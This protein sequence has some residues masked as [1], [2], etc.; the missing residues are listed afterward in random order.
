MS[1][2]WKK[3]TAAVLATVMTVTI[4]PC[5]KIF[6]IQAA[7]GA[8]EPY[9]ISLGRPVYVSS[10][11]GNL[12]GENGVDGRED[13]RWQASQSDE[14]EWFYVDLGKTTEIDS[15]YIHWEDAYAKSYD[16]QFSD[17][18]EQWETVYTRGNKPGSYVNM[19]ISYSVAYNDDNVLVT[20]ANWTT[21]ENAKYAVYDGEDIAKA[22]DGYSFTGHGDAGGLIQ[23]E[24]GT[25]TLKVVALDKTTGEE[26]GSGI[27][28]V[29]VT[30]GSS[31]NNGVE[32]DTDANLKHTILKEELSATSAR[33]VKI[34]C[35]ERATDYGC[36]FY[37]FQV[38][39]QDGV[40]KRPED[41]G[42]N[43][44]LNKK[45]ECSGLR[46][47]WW[48]T[49][50]E[51]NLDQS[52]VLAENAVDG[53]ENT[54]FTS[55][56]DINQ[57]LS[58]DLGQ[59]YTVGRIV[60]D[61]TGD[62]AKVYDYQVSIDGQK[63]Q[64]VYRNLKGVPNST[65]NVQVYAEN[66][67]YVR[68]Y[69]Y[70]KVE[71]GSGIGIKELS[72]YSYQEGEEKITHTITPLPDTEVVE[73]GKGS[74]LSN[75]M[76][77]EQA[78]VPY[79]KTEDIQTPIDS[80][81]WW[82]SMLIY[83]FGNVMCTLPFKTR[84]STKGLSVLTA[85]DGWLQDHDET[86]VN[87]SV[88]SE[89]QTDFYI[90]PENLDTSSA[91]DK[92]S[93][94]G[95]FSVTAQLCDDDHVAMEN[96]FVKGSPYIYSDFKDTRSF[97]INSPNI[98]SVFDGQGAEILE[99]GS[100]TADCIG[101]EITD[102][103]NQ[104]KTDTSKSYYCLNLP[105]GT[106]FKKV[107]KNIRVTFMGADRYMSLGTM[108][109]KDQMQKFH[110]QGYAFV[111]GTAVTYDYDD[112]NAKITSVYQAETNVKR[113]GFSD[114]TLMCMLP[115]QWKNSS[116]DEGAF[117]TYPSVRGDM[118]AIESNS[119][120]TLSDFSGLVPTFAK[121]GGTKEGNT[122]FDSE[123]VLGYL[124][125]LE[126][127]TKNI[128]P[129][130]DAYWEGKNLHP[131]GMGVIMADQIGETEL[132]DTFLARLKER[133][134]DWF[135]YSGEDDISYFIYNPGWGT[136]YYKESEFGA[137]AAICDH[138][139]TYGYFVFGAVVLATYDKEFYN[140][141][142]DM[143]DML[144]RDY[145]NPVKDE[146]YCR[147]RAYD[148]Y[149]GHSWAGGYADND[150]GNNQESASES[151]FSWVSMYLWG[152]LTEN[153]TYRDAGVF[154]FT[155]E[156]EAV[157][158]YWFDY[159]GDNWVEAWPYDVVAQVYGGINFYGT[160]F[161]GQPLYCYGIQWLPISEYLTY[162]G[163][164]QKRC[165]EIYQGLL[166]DTDIAM[167]KAV[168]AAQNEGKT[169]EEIDK[170]LQDYP[171]ADNGWQHITWPFLALTDPDGAMEKF[172]ANDSKVQ[173]TDTAMTYWYINALKENGVRSSQYKVT[174][175]GV[176][177]SVYYQESENKYTAQ[178][179]NPTEK[180]RVATVRK[181]DGTV[182][183]TV[184]A[185]PKSLI[186]F[187]IDEDNTFAYTQLSAPSIK[188]TSLTAGTVEENVS[189]VHRFDDT[190]LIELSCNDSEA[191]IYYTT[192]GTAPT[193]DS[194]RYE[195]GEK[196]LVSTDTVIKAVAVKEG[197]ID[198]SYGAAT[199]QIDGD[200][201]QNQE[202]L[203]LGKTAMAS[204]ENGA[205][206]AMNVTDGKENTRW[207]S[208][209]DD[210]GES[211]WV[212]LGKTETVNTV[213]IK[214]E[215]AYAGA[216]DILVSIDGKE[217]EKVASET[218]AEGY[219]ETTF[220]AVN[221]RYVKMQTQKRATQ[222]G[223]SL[224]EFEIYGARKADMPAIST[225]SGVYDTP[226][227]ITM[228]TPVKGAEIKYTLDGSDPTE[229]SPS[230]TEPV[231]IEKSSIV[232]AVTYR[233]GMI[234]SDVVQADI[235]IKGTVT[236]SKTEENIAI[237]R[238]MQLAA[239]TDE[240]V[241]WSSSNEEVATVDD[242]GLVTG[243]KEGTVEIA[244]TISNGEKAVCKITVTPPIHIEKIELSPSEL[245]MKNKSTQTLELMIYPED[246]TDDTTATW[247]SSD[248]EVLTVNSFGTVTAK[249][250][251]TATVTVTVGDYTASCHITVGP[252]ATV[253]EMVSDELYNAALGKEVTISS[254]YAGEGSQ[255]TDV[256]TDGDLEGSYVSTDWDQSRT[257]EYLLIDLGA[258]YETAGLDMVMLKFVNE[259]TFCN[260]YE[261]QYS[262]NGVEFFTV[263]K[264]DSVSYEDTDEGT[265]TVKIDTAQAAELTG[266]TR[267]VK[268]IMTGHKNWGF[269]IREVAVLSTEQNLQYTETQKCEAPAQFYA[270]SENV[271]EIT[272]TIKAGEEQEGYQY[273]VLLDGQRISENATGAGT[274]TVKNVSYGT[275][276]L[277]AMS[278]YQ[279]K[280]SDPLRATV[281][282]ED[283]SLVHYIDTE[284]N[285]AKGADV[286]VED[287]YE[288][289]G[290]QNAKVLT[291]GKISKDLADVV[292]TM[293]AKQNAVITIDLGENVSKYL[294]DE[295]ILA[296]KADNT[297]AT[298][299]NVQFSS[300]GIHYEKVLDK[301]EV[302]YA[303]A[304]EDKVDVSSYSQDT[305]KYVRINLTN[306]NYNWGYQLSEVAV[307]KKEIQTNRNIQV[308]GYQISV[309]HEGFRVVA[310]VED[311]INDKK[312][313]HWGLVYGLSNVDGKDTGITDEDVF[314][315]DDHYYVKAYESTVNGTLSDR[316]SESETATNYARI[317]KFG[318]FTVKAF[319][320][321]YK[322]RAYALLEDGT[323]VYSDAAEFSVFEVAGYLY[324]N[325]MM[326]TKEEHDYLYE[327]IL[328]KVQPGYAYVDKDWSDIMK[329]VQFHMIP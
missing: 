308:E 241:A 27:C 80:N 58:V 29:N 322:V 155:N 273:I 311:T 290:S 323:Y 181:E 28:E 255:D 314:V 225:L 40:V 267:Y 102:N 256:L 224:Y 117:A 21:V 167:D 201:I 227:S 223:S 45:V 128:N 139:F 252:A 161:G 188:A 50:E 146:E 216:Y 163:T 307:M 261:I 150:S 115:H 319:T 313:E 20:S 78:K 276:E 151:L 12:S 306:G 226:Q 88:I 303:E 122:T 130:A 43:I 70:T 16:I 236:L 7:S 262:E 127:A 304:L 145:A 136:I 265:Y 105:E 258:D 141:Y 164:E 189:G 63:W 3:V 153:D 327:K 269:Q 125:Q 56:N 35:N 90:V 113:E 234:L 14:N 272:Y 92:V 143:I 208:A 156:M 89:T 142:K 257:E 174:G 13:T 264:T 36:S 253:E 180:N 275:H 248:T 260:D 295:I 284:R 55:K 133:L 219:V 300:D 277:Q 54:S 324:D 242:T 297:N 250:E 5:G 200:T 67:R 144:I 243:I 197:C 48:M 107:G 232:K 190:Q 235:I 286:F 97:T 169:Q 39:G 31:G 103:D 182:A 59:A 317:M 6:H 22:P 185:A 233:K 263:A 95:D 209:T 41:Y 206:T 194:I 30:D 57:W 165:A 26:L 195:T 294:I 84:Y 137:N 120:S 240:K 172:L 183:G 310:S 111:T 112:E 10:E 119:F 42:E 68:I 109:S 309:L 132:R 281:F 211:V 104:A 85:T 15:I 71:K 87:L 160:F 287:I 285:L 49:D 237:G 217:W 114:T 51:G 23:L 154:G 321:R 289:E 212:D 291:D 126:N 230:Y 34:V 100:I 18:E 222:Y 79:Y 239:I 147:F 246:T 177:G 19:A 81:D 148:L 158:Q 98:T 316:Y 74:Y 38:Y 53:D 280:Y 312:V 198:S 24:E 66:V 96:T 305:V 244:A 77:S 283:G 62:A 162:Y 274:Y 69:G 64:T 157:K 205:D 2:F 214:W 221:A 268:I 82:Q 179:Y 86:A 301:T 278:Y 249:K 129:A 186:S 116:D 299:Y 140:D 123:A 61:W 271:H 220:E 83:R 315:R 91:C 210:V 293:W 213:K 192:D 33:Y 254:I 302:A 325:K 37:E 282:V 215:A 166:D 176:S 173:N 193:T 328:T 326:S 134:T 296:F 8:D 231:V 101:L 99:S 320:A 47:E 121:P 118:K 171:Q 168:E 204:T 9:N 175:D 178:V 259:S 229:N 279:G 159:D 4:C 202:N 76:Y 73:K 266:K 170:I 270:V 1:K 149:E 135:T 11:N 191:L 199:I 44:A 138:H 218:G 75:D 32:I 184:T 17:D 238:T 329:P 187:T 106:V 52:S 251:G 108:Q 292:E 25:H 288:N 196:I 152:V 247:V 46:E 131:L 65:D 207:Q 60:V 124:K 318:A 245:T 110:E 228:S 72:V 298:A 94:Y 203:A 93:G